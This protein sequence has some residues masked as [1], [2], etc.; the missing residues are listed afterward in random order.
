MLVTHRLIRRVFIF[1]ST[2]LL[3]SRRRPMSLALGRRARGVSFL[4]DGKN[5]PG[6]LKDAMVVEGER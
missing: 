4:L 3:L 1:C 6:R 5:D 2:L